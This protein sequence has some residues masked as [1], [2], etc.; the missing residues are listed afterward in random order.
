L[1]IFSISALEVLSKDLLASKEAS[2]SWE[3]RCEEG[4]AADDCLLLAVED[5]AAAVRLLDGIPF[6]FLPPPVAK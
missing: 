1:R 4:S 6:L 5:E 2:L 3:K